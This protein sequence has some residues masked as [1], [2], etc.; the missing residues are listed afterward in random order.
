[1]NPGHTGPA[2]AYLAEGKASGRYYGA[3]D[4]DDR[5]VLGSRGGAGGRFCKERRLWYAD[6]REVCLAMLQT[7]KWTPVG[8]DARAVA[9]ILGKQLQAEQ[10]AAWAAQVQKA[11]SVKVVLTEAQKDSIQ[12]KDLG[13]QADAPE[14]VTW[15]ADRGLSNEIIAAS[16]KWAELGPRSGLSDAARLV[17]AL[18]TPY[19]RGG[20]WFSQ[21][22]PAYAGAPLLTVAQALAGGPPPA[23]P[24]LP[25]RRAVPPAVPSDGP[26]PASAS[27]AAPSSMRPRT[28]SAP[29]PAPQRPTVQ[30]RLRRP[31]DTI[32]RT[33][34]QRVDDQFLDC[35]CRGRQWARCGVC[36]IL[37]SH[38]QRCGCG[39]GE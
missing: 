25:K 20:I 30:V 8:A 14:H 16:G 21:T 22:S 5:Q 28:P 36:D 1:M 15:L 10:D 7:G 23:P 24:R 27:H 34:H 4:F 33:C 29:R 18:K 17:R 31:P 39:D 19:E 13:V 3:S 35:D 2:Q 11:Q 6:S 9:T 26:V 32:C 37:C 12:R 38:G